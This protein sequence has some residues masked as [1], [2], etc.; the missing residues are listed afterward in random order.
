MAELQTIKRN[1]FISTDDIN[2]GGE[3]EA[4]ETDKDNLVPSSSQSSDNIVPRKPMEPLPIDMHRDEIL[5][6]LTRDRLV[7]IHGETGRTKISYNDLSL[8]AIIFRV[9]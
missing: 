8:T 4:I 5:D 3:I 7:M 1:A 6:K 9:W 2:E